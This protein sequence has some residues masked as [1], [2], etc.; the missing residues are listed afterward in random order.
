M[1]FIDLDGL[2]T[3]ATEKSSL[4]A[5]EETPT[6]VFESDEEV[7][8]DGKPVKVEKPEKPNVFRRVQNKA[9]D[10]NVQFKKK[11]AEGKR[12]A[13]DAKNAGK[14]V[15]KIPMNVADSVKKQVNEWDDLDDDRR[16]EYIM[17]P[18]FRKKYFRALRLC[19]MHYGA[20][21]INPVLNI[22][23]FI[24]QKASNEKNIRIRNEVYREL[25]AEIKVT[26]EKIEDAK[27][28]GDNKQKYKLMRIK[29]KLEAERMRIGT[30]S[31]YI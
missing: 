23:L 12:K 22:V 3:E 4:S 18:G 25:N 19:I 13:V 20:F 2:T 28:N 1:D 29:E 7:E 30:N 17:K 5:V 11:V 21:A 31:K 6:T 14:A 8:N 9:L 27:A 16:K 15:S 10:T 26:E 24:C